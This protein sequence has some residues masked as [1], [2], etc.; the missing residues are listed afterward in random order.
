LAYYWTTERGMNP[1]EPSSMHSILK[2]ILPPGRQEP[3]LKK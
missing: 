2:S 3:E 1:D